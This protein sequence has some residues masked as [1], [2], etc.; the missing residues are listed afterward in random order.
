[1]RHF[2]FILYFLLIV[3]CY[4]QQQKQN[5]DITIRGHIGVPAVLSSQMFRTAF[6]GVYETDLSVNYR[7][8][9]NL[10]AGVGYQNV[11]FQNNKGVFVFYKTPQGSLSYNTRIMGHSPIIKLGYDYFFSDNGFISYAVNIGY[12]FARYTNVVIDTSQQ[13][14]PYGALSFSAPL[15]QPEVSFNFNVEDNLVFSFYFAYNNLLYK[16]D[17]KSPRFNHVARVNE[18][19][20][21]Y[22]MSWLTLGFGF[23]VILK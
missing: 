21:N 16:F 15:V 11:F 23:S 2:F 20:N 19:G 22:I 13:N 9:K 12:M 4:G 10:Y 18:A 3:G 7:V 5:A 17:P 6:N 8:W 14:R 1:M